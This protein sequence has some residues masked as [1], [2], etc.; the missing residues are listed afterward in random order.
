[1]LDARVQQGLQELGG[2]PLRSFKAEGDLPRVCWAMYYIMHWK[3]DQI[4]GA[5]PCRYLAGRGGGL[6]P[7]GYLKGLSPPVGHCRILALHGHGR[8]QAY[9]WVAPLL[10]LNDGE[11]DGVIQHRGEGIHK[12]HPHDHRAEEIGPHVHHSP[13]CQP[14]SRTPLQRTAPL[15]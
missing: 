8:V 5:A 10:L 14:T 12:R 9:I 3:D 1:M 2:S 7:L 11:R 15:A 6:S 13:H 4:Q